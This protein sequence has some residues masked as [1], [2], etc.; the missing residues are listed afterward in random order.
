MIRPLATFGLAASMAATSAFAFDINALSTEDRAAFGDAVR[1]YLLENPDVIVEAINVLETRQQEAQAQA[2]VNLVAQYA[3]ALFDDGFSW[4]G[5]NP[6]GDIVLVEFMDYRCGY[7]RRA[8]P[9]VLD[10]IANDG[11]IKLVV[12][13]F[14]ILGE[15]SMI[16]SRFAIATKHVAGDEAYSQVHEAL[17]A[18]TGDPSDVALRRIADE[19]GLDADPILEKM[20]S[21]DVT[22]EIATTRALAQALQ[23]NGTPTFVLHDELLRGFVP[24]DQMADIVSDKRG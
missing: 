7:C 8:H 10:L 20:D 5:G 11:N 1:A 19:L 2:D 23:I 21:D 24:A 15:A 4:V 14:P 16:S 9:E 18:F 12:K 13:E 3:D 17:I 6:D 22:S